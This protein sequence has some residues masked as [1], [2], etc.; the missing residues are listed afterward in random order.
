MALTNGITL[1][2]KI[3][4]IADAIRSK[5]HK[6]NSLTID[7][8]V[9]E[10]NNEWKIT[11]YVKDFYIQDDGNHGEEKDGDWG[12]RLDFNVAESGTGAILSYTLDGKIALTARSIDTTSFENVQWRLDSA[13]EGVT[14]IRHDW[15]SAVTPSGQPGQYQTCFLKG[16]NNYCRIIV[17]C[18]DRHE[19]GDKI[20][21]WIKVEYI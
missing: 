21:L 8:M 10:I 4:T 9:S 18:G 15:N 17:W 19:N 3:K 5:T 16:I 14:L 12:D 11:C 6:T 13:P 1:W 7:Q 20:D 2:N